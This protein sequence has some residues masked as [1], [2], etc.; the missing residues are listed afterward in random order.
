MVSKSIIIWASFLPA[1]SLLDFGKP[2][3]ILAVLI[4][5]KRDTQ[6]FFKFEFYHIQKEKGSVYYKNHCF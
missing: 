3:L 6:V 4:I 5:P 2:L 1:V